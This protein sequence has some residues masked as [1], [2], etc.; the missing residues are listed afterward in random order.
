[1]IKYF[2]AIWREAP[3]VQS[4]ADEYSAHIRIRCGRLFST[5]QIVRVF[6]LELVGLE[7][8][9][10]S[11][12]LNL[13]DVRQIQGNLQEWIGDANCQFSIAPGQRILLAPDLFEAGLVAKVGAAPTAHMEDLFITG[14]TI[15]LQQDA[16]PS[17]SAPIL[18]VHQ[19][20]GRL[21]NWFLLPKPNLSGWRT[22]ELLIKHRDPPNAN[23]IASLRAVKLNGERTVE[24]ANNSKYP[25]QLHLAP[26]GEK[27]RYPPNFGG[28]A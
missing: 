19:W 24:I 3:P 5:P 25:F 9:K 23:P 26:N 12:R 14:C 7:S 2:A 17:S 28:I 15:G 8:K 13:A 1:M 11:V 18:S 4:L 10:A 6:T 20:R 16:V 22:L 21:L 27:L